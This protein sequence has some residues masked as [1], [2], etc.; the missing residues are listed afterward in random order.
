MSKLKNILLGSV[1]L[2]STACASAPLTA[3]RDD[4]VPT[5]T[6]PSGSAPRQFDCAGANQDSDGNTRKDCLPNDADGAAR[7]TEAG[8]GGTLLRP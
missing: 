2:L 4:D 1:L 7:D 6:A 5:K 8:S 3:N